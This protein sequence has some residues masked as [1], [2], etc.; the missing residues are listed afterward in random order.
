MG[1]RLAFTLLLLSS[2][3]ASMNLHARDI[4][5]ARIHQGAGG[6]E[7][8]LA[9]S[10]FDAG[11]AEISDRQY[12]DSLSDAAFF[13]LGLARQQQWRPV[14]DGPLLR[15]GDR[16]VQIAQLRQL[17]TMYG[18]L[19][20]DSEIASGFYDPLV[21]DPNLK[22]ALIRFQIRHGAKPDGVLGPKTRAV[23][24]ISPQQRAYQ[25]ALNMERQSTFNGRFQSRYIHVNIPEYRLR[26]IEEG[27]EVLA[28]KTIIGRS[29]RQT[30]VLESQIRSLVINPSWN[31]PK[32]IAYKDILP[33]WQE[34]S[35]YLEKNNLKVVSGWSN[36]WQE[37]PAEQVDQSRMYR[38][39]EYFR[40]VQ[41]PG[42]TN[43]LGRVK[44]LFPNQHEV[45]LHDTPQ[46][47]LF[48]E[49]NR[50]FS[51]GC[52]RLENPMALAKTLMKT[53]SIMRSSRLK[54][55][56]ASNTTK[57]L[58][59]REPVPL[60]LTYWTAWLDDNQMLHFGE[61]VYSQDELEA[62]AKFL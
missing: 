56:L 44:F 19:S 6:A 7:Q 49:A 26:Y 9:V 55:L 12:F 35:E 34:D 54:K 21:F 62:S 11:V 28:M 20:S 33:R 37:Y 31:V 48:K 1:H 42:K 24:N 59:L 60:Y 39:K 15:V 25:I 8:A 4:A 16:H 45:Y 29:T 58:R 53:S 41:P 10:D 38:G 50:A 52:I 23:L 18:D 5:G 13:Y 47:S 36:R 57:Q 3:L 14:P 51:S 27:A 22:E 32:G 2:T 30:P 46:R 17:L 40:F 61:D 43:A